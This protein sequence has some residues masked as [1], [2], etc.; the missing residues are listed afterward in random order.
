LRRLLI[1]LLWQRHE[2]RWGRLFLRLLIGLR[3]LR[4]R[5]RVHNR[6]W[7]CLVGYASDTFDLSGYWF[8]IGVQILLVGVVQLGSAVQAETVDLG[9]LTSA[10]SAKCHGI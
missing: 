9:I 5:L 6:C 10:V 2:H 4:C 7:R 1:L 3:V 8:A